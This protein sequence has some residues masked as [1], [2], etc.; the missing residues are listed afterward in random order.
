MT[1]L[2]A[3]F[4]T[5]VYGLVC[6]LGVTA[7][8]CV[9]GIL[10]LSLSVSLSCICWRAGGEAHHPPEQFGSQ[11]L[12]IAIMAD[13]VVLTSEDVAAQENV[14]QAIHDEL[15]QVR[16]EKERL[17]AMVDEF[18]TAH[19]DTIT[20]N[21]EQQERIREL[22]QE[23]LAI[24]NRMAELEYEQEEPLPAPAPVDEHLDSESIG[25]IDPAI[26]AAQAAELQALRDRLDEIAAENEQLR[27]NAPQEHHDQGDFATTE[28]SFSLA[29]ELASVSLQEQLEMEARQRQLDDE[30]RRRLEAENRLKS[31]QVEQERERQAYLELQSR[32]AE[33]E[34]AFERERQLKADSEQRIADIEL[35]QRELVAT[36][37]TLA[38]S[39]PAPEAPPSVPDPLVLLLEHLTSIFPTLAREVIREVIHKHKGDM[40]KIMPE[41]L[42]LSKAMA[43]T[44]AAQTPRVS[45][46]ATPRRVVVSRSGPKVPDTH[47]NPFANFVSSPTPK[48][49]VATAS[50]PRPSPARATV[51]PRAPAVRP[52]P[53]AVHIDPPKAIPAFAL[54]EEGPAARGYDVALEAEQ[55]DQDRKMAEAFA[56]RAP[57]FNITLPSQTHI[58]RV[59][60]LDTQEARDMGLGTRFFA[61]AELRVTP[62]SIGLMSHVNHRP[63]VEWPFA[64]VK[65]IC[66]DTGRMLI[67]GWVH[68]AQRAVKLVLNSHQTGDAYPCLCEC[69]HEFVRHRDEDI[70]RALQKEELAG[71]MDL[72]DAFLRELRINDEFNRILAEET[73]NGFQDLRAKDDDAYR[74]QL[75]L[76]GTKS[77]NMLRKIRLKGSKKSKRTAS[78]ASSSGSSSSSPSAAGKSPRSGRRLFGRKQ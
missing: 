54:R 42:E 56:A 28:G 12:A 22:E 9:C 59:E 2:S 69:L 77:Q 60:L 19:D 23:K 15:M 70:A 40:D 37:P 57:E 18:R 75:L 16:Y 34:A 45:H 33:A 5:T 71:V 13:E 43:E 6:L 20:D 61:Q 49:A 52:A 48:K 76:M 55:R 8:V 73:K 63:I 78:H 4:S 66:A 62:H 31:L 47:N 38:A 14:A 53:P 26:V 64:L 32:L 67:E 36:A 27:R 24:A 50:K 41:L 30:A 58:F 3:I 46:T 35:K 17:E 29:D 72:S 10:S 1:L 74:Q 25:G 68:A 51:S 7:T 44:S 39:A 11:A 21:F 65:S